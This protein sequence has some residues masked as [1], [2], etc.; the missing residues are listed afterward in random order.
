MSG[1]HAPEEDGAALET[2]PRGRAGLERAAA[3]LA[4]R[5]PPPAWDWLLLVLL[6]IVGA[7][8][9][10]SQT[11][12]TVFADDEWIWILTRRGG[13]IGTFLD[14]HN[15]HLSLVPVI[16]Y[17][18]LFA[19]AGMRHYWPYRVVVTAAHVAVTALVFMYVRTRAGRWP[20]L[21]GAALILFFGP[22]W[23]DFLWPFQV[24]WLIA[25]GAGVAALLALDRRDRLGDVLACLLLAVSLASAGPGLA[26]AAGMVVELALARARRRAWI[27]AIPIALYA[28]WWIGYQQTNVSH[29][30]V[31]YV[32]R[33]VFDAA[34]GVFSS[35][36]GLSASNALNGTGDFVTWGAPLLAAFAF[37]VAWRYRAGLRSVPIRVW[38]LA[39]T[40]VVFW[41]L[42]AVGRAYV[43]LGSAVLTSTGDES[44]YLYIGAVIVLLLAAEALRGVRL[45][46]PVGL[47]ASVLVAA[48]V[49]SNVGSLRDGAALLKAES[50]QTVVE[51]GTLD[52]TRSI[53][54]PSYVSQGFV[55]GIVTAG[56]YFRAQDALGS[57]AASPA[58]IAVA[59][60]AARSAADSQLIAIHHVVLAPLGALTGSPAGRGL[61]VD[62]YSGVRGT[63]VAGCAVFTDSAFT[64]AGA[65]DT[66]DLTLPASGVE[67]EAMGGPATVGLRRFSDQF[68][69]LGTLPPGRPAGLLIG[70]DAAPQPW[71]VQIAPTASV[72]VC[73]G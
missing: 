20:A 47:V 35:L 10:L 25:L 33:F 23:Q 18:L 71:H 66:V 7:V 65:T 15:S 54:S 22:G 40:A 46:L 72:R 13:G 44:R 5:R 32:T 53:V 1:V 4:G 12:G 36:A 58:Q 60:P 57:V 6:L 9:L 51:L 3:K 43:T 41:I 28:L 50:Q 52:M 29:D 21:L 37:A 70:P 62:A 67:I 45:G 19:T 69:T 38:T 11:R 34:A 17:K 42:T 26:V 68:Q 48:A 49:L 24:A 59:A 16:I 55:F 14:P 61:R 39:A 31:F 56:P 30:S 2:L 64:P 27:V 63:I 73:A 8:F